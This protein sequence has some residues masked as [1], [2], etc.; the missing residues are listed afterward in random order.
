MKKLMALMAIAGASVCTA[1]TVTLKSKD[2]GGY[3]AFIDGTRW[4]NGVPPTSGNDYVVASG[5]EMRT[6]QYYVQTSGVTTNAVFAGDSLTLGDGSNFGRLVVKTT[7]E[8]SYKGCASVTVGDLRLANANSYVQHAG[9]YQDARL[10]GKITFSVPQASITDSAVPYLTGNNDRYLDVYSELVSAAGCGFKVRLFDGDMPFHVALMSDSPSYLGYIASDGGKVYLTA[11][12]AGALGPEP[13]TPTALMNLRNGGAFGVEY[14][15]VTIDQPNRGI[16]I[17]SASGGRLYAASGKTF[18]T[19]MFIESEA[20]PRPVEKTGDGTVLVTGAYGAGDITVSGGRLGLDGAVSR[21]VTVSDGCSFGPATADSTLTLSG[22]ITF[23]GSAHFYVPLGAVTELADGFTS[24]VWPIPLEMGGDWTDAAT[25]VTVFR[26]SSSVHVFAEAEL[27]ALSAMCG[28]AH[29]NAFHFI[30]STDGGVQTVSCVKS[31]VVKETSTGTSAYWGDANIW[32]SKK[33]PESGYTYVVGNGK[34]CRSNDGGWDSVAFAGDRLEFDGSS[35]YS[36]Y[37][38]FLMKAKTVAVPRLAMSGK[39]EIN[40]AGYSGDSQHHEQTLNGSLYMFPESYCVVNSCWDRLLTLNAPLF[41]AGTIHLVPNE[42]DTSVIGT[43]TSH[44]NEMRVALAADNSAWLGSLILSAKPDSYNGAVPTD[45][46][47]G[48]VPVELIIADGSNVGGNPATYDENSFRI[49]ARCRLTATNTLELA[50][51]NR[52][53]KV[54]QYAEMCVADGKTMTITS[55]L[56]LNGTLTKSGAGTLALGCHAAA[57]TANTIS[58]AE[59]FLAAS[60]TNGFNG[61][62]VAVSSGAAIKVPLQADATTDLGRFGFCNTGTDEPFDLTD[63]GGT[64]AIAVSDEG[65]RIAA[66]KSGGAG[67][68]VNVLTVS[69]A[70]ADRLEGR[71]EVHSEDG[72]EAMKTIRNAADAAGRVTFTSAFHRQGLIISMY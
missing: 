14:N 24:S 22:A 35:D 2:P 63:C 26:V 59:G 41:G 25:T 34:T 17:S 46:N 60:T 4:S 31:T 70:A 43:S 9:N 64:L 7:A 36:S 12:S 72:W 38:K 56:I 30:A 51:A 40:V 20:T 49:S 68:S 45:G 47:E 61:V 67:V 37:A 28:I 69:E 62:T 15:D 58:L 66:A 11:E 18:Q 42:R 52:P 57:S 19:S 6:P 71:I 32:D 21:A 8:T 39:T 65:G 10:C 48:I 53:V 1:D 50:C 29:D 13:E 33:V 5:L 54:E 16:Y 23:N 3:S 27:A 44:K 55:P